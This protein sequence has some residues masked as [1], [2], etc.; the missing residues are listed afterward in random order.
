MSEAIDSLRAEW[1]KPGVVPDPNSPGWNA[2]FD[3]IDGELKTYAAAEQSEARGASLGR[4]AYFSA[5]LR[6]VAWEPSNRIQA[7]LDAWL[8]PRLKLAEAERSVLAVVQASVQADPS[9]KTN[10]DGWIR[11]VDN[12]LASSLKAYEEAPTVAVRR[13]A[14][15]RLKLGLEAIRGGN[16]TRPW[17][18]SLAL[19]Q[20]LGGLWSL[21]NLDITA[22]TPTLH[23]LLAANLVTSGPVF[24]KGYWSQV[25]AGPYLGFQLLPSDDGIA[26]TNSQALSSVTPITDFQS[27]LE[28]DKRGRRVAK[29]YQVGATSFSSPTLTV[30]VV[31]RPSGLQIIPTYQHSVNA[32]IS[33]T[34]QPG[35]G[36]GRAIASLVGFNQGR[37][38]QEIYNNAIPEI[39]QNVVKESAEE[40]NERTSAEAAQRNAALSKFLIGNNTLALG[41][42]L[43]TGLD[44]R[45]R[46]EFAL[47]GGK[48][49]WKDLPSSV[50]AESPQPTKFAAPSTGITAD[51]HLGSILNNLADGY[52]ISDQA[53]AVENVMI[54]TQK[55]PPG[56]SP[57]DGVK[58]RTNVDF[59]AY[60]EAV[61]AAKAL[62]DPAAQAIR[63]KKPSKPPEFEADAKGNLVAL[64]KDFQLEVPAP[65]QAAKGGGLIGP[66]AQIYRIVSPQAEFAISVQIAPETPTSPLR[67]TG[68]V[69]EFD[70]G[71][72]TKIYAIN[73]DESKAVPLSGLTTNIVLAA[74]RLKIQGQPLDLPL[75]NLPLRGFIIREVSPLDPTGWMRLVL[76]RDPNAQADPAIEANANP[77]VAAAAPITEP[78]AVAPPPV[79]TDPAAVVQ[80]VTPAE[81][82]P[83][84]PATPPIP[85]PSVPQPGTR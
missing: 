24:R 12:E 62:N 33:T 38:T 72:G 68:R 49:V 2:I 43:V 77:P 18:P 42:V 3:A 41:N 63:V 56:A 39:Q 1:T 55:V 36:F 85:N 59:N 11:F 75:S 69:E 71:L 35:G 40:T 80:P 6:G 46:P 52:L 48:L 57:R 9:A 29:M 70:P 31:I 45:S 26:F 83:L 21:P 15:A 5:A 73:D 82:Q 66:P 64:V 32:L 20:A 67:L 30:L 19:E 53:K 47:I 84:V 74:A 50:G 79:A 78:A 51:V 81:P 10:G 25:T 13:Q 4:L 61:A 28:Q 23:P 34:P 65:P 27:Q 44:F 60:R 7:A 37:I 17:G 8:Q 22:D 58:V 76:A 54:E 16:Q 14:F